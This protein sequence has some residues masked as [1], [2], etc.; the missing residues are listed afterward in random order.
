SSLYASLSNGDQ[1][2]LPVL[3]FQ[4][5][6]CRKVYDIILVC[7]SKH[8]PIEDV[9]ENL[10]IAQGPF[11]FCVFFHHI[12]QLAK[13]SVSAHYS[14]IIKQ[15]HTVLGDYTKLSLVMV[16]FNQSVATFFTQLHSNKHLECDILVNLFLF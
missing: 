1:L 11:A 2:S 9:R 4:V 13:L 16:P 6:L 15:Y 3:R 8:E 7:L 12:E 14:P 10:F 5:M